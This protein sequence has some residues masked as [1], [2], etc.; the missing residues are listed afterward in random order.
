MLHPKP[1]KVE[2]LTK[3]KLKTTV[4]ITRVTTMAPQHQKIKLK[5][6]VATTLVMVMLPLN[7]HH[8]PPLQTGALVTHSP[9]PCAPN[10]TLTLSLLS[11]KKAIGALN[12]DFLSLFAP[13]VTH[14]N[15]RN[16]HNQPHPI[17]TSVKIGAQNIFSQS[18]PAPFATPASQHLFKKKAT[19]APNTDFLS[20]FAPLVIL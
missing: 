3:P 1:N 6:P 14:Q 18:P 12:T 19:G 11:K 13:L 2:N 8:L 4:K 16:L 9:N 5:I 20:L 17:P 15:P 10:V 7:L